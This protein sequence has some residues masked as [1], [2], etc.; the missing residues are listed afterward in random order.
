MEPPYVLMSHSYGGIAARAFLQTQQP[1][2]V[3]GMTL[4]DTATELLYEL[5]QPQIPP[6]ALMAVA[7]GVDLA[8]LTHLRE[9][10]GL[11]EQEYCDVLKAV[12]RTVPGAETE[13]CRATASNLLRCQQFP[14]HTASP[15]PVLVIC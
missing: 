1:C 8:D 6:P 2:A 4:V 12:E 15:W 10:M 5:F 14:N 9:D 11:S 13:D 7:K 3:Q